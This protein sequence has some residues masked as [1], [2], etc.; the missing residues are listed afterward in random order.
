MFTALIILLLAGLGLLLLQRLEFR[1]V[2]PRRAARRAT[3]ASQRE[4]S[5]KADK[6][7]G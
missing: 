5:W 3:R 1:S 4:E 2:F 6:G 7:E